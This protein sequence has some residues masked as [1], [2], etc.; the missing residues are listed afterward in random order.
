MQAGSPKLIGDNYKKL[1]RIGE[2]GYGRVTKC[3]L[4][5]S[6]EEEKYYAIKKYFMNRVNKLKIIKQIYSINK[7]QKKEKNDTF[8]KDQYEFIKNLN[9]SNIIKAIEYLEWKK[10]KYIVYDYHPNDLT[11][12]IKNKNLNWEEI[13]IYAKQIFEALNY[14][15]KKKIIHRDIKPDNFLIDENDKIILCDFDLARNFENKSQI[16]TKNTCTSY[17]KPPEILV[18]S[19][20]YDEKIDIWGAGCVIYEMIMKKPL[21]EIQSEFGILFKVIEIVGSPNVR[22]EINPLFFRKIIGRI[23]GRFQIQNI[24]QGRKQASEFK[25]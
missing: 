18:G 10:N 2:G 19:T 7:D 11:K 9:H 16:K 25:R 4:V 22:H 8:V 21:F 23:V 14:L 20:T 6:T 12:L 5:N 15:H 17:Y 1:E 3:S 13:K 24:S